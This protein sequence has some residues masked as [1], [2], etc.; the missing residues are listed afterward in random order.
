MA[1]LARV[2]TTRREVTRSHAGTNRSQV[3]DNHSTTSSSSLP[4]SSAAPVAVAVTVLSAREWEYE[5]G[6]VELIRGDT[7]R[8]M[9][10][11]LKLDCNHASTIITALRTLRYQLLLDYPAEALLHHSSL[12]RVSPCAVDR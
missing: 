9:D 5:F 3:Y 8:I 1:S 11:A 12:P 2:S 4:V 7:R 10:I 6:E